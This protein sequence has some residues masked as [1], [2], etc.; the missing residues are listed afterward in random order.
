LTLRLC[1]K[2]RK[3]RIRNPKKRISKSEAIRQKFENRNR[4]RGNP[5]SIISSSD[6]GFRISDFGICA[7]ALCAMVEAAARITAAGLKLTLP[8]PEGKRRLVYI[9]IL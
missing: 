1:P 2:T 5:G 3:P 8:V 9:I 4:K 7:K 6:F